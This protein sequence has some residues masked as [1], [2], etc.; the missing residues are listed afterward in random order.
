MPLRAWRTNKEASN[1]VYGSV[2][3]VGISDMGKGWQSNTNTMEI[4][5]KLIFY[6]DKTMGDKMMYILNDDTQNY[7]FCRL[8]LVVENT[9]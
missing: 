4:A 2:R 5:R 6:R 1:I 8:K 3:D 7:P 9:F